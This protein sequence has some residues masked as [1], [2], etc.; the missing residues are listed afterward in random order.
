MLFDAQSEFREQLSAP[1]EAAAVAS[2]DGQ[3]ALSS[4]QLQ[5]SRLD[6]VGKLIFRSERSSL[7][8]VDFHK[9]PEL[10]QS[11]SFFVVQCPF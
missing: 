5:G 7:R 6:D 9:Q 2:L 1:T 8:S 4:I 11:L 10:G 3:A